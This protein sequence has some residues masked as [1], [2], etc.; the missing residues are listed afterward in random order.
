MVEQHAVLFLD[1]EETPGRWDDVCND[2]D[3]LALDQVLYGQTRA[4][5]IFNGCVEERK[6]SVSLA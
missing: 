1:W 4:I 5:Q 2:A 3:H 6:T